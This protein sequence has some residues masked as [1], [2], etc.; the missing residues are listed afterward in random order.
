V[1]H[2]PLPGLV[3]LGLVLL[4]AEGAG[5]AAQWQRN[6]DC[7]ILA[8]LVEGAIWAVAALVVCRGGRQSLR[9]ILAVAV[10]MR[11][12]ALAAPVY[13]S[14]DIYRYVWDGR[15]TG[16]GVNPYRYIPDDP[17][18]AALRDAAIFPNINRAV[19]ARTIYP[20]AAEVLFFFA[21][22]FGGGILAM[23]LAMVAAEA[24]GIVALLSVL[25]AAGRPRQQILL[26]VWHPLPVWEIAGCGHVDAAVVMFVALAF[27]AA[28]RGRRAASAAA[29]AAAT[30]VKFLP[31]VLVPAFWR[32][33]RANRGD[34]C[35]PAVF[36]AVC[37]AAYLPFLGAGWRV[38]GFLPGY[39]AEE[40][41]QAGGGFWL[42]ALVRRAVPL[43][44]AAYLGLSAAALLA[45]AGVAWRP[46]AGAAPRLG[47]AT[48]LA[49][50]ALFLLSP[51]YAWYFVWLVALLCVAPWWPAWW[52]TLTAVLLYK[53]SMTGEIPRVAGIVIYGGFALFAAGDMVR[54]L[55][56]D[57]AAGSPP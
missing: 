30:L 47:P 39:L 57:A 23:K 3:S 18:L 52:P 15:V 5:L 9:L 31:L 42:L 12:V 35:W 7:F 38:L 56:L 8:V 46:R 6:I 53:Q 44:T 27:S 19:Y 33:T 1:R 51:H 34:W 54:H 45:L 36:A 13:L 55:V 21:T 2:P 17:Q 49:S 14:T 16:A 22:R 4:A 10:L 32:P 29:L 48:L 24:V 11:L 41:L 37:A 28:M 25:R 40:H 50:A 26:Y 20:P 43:S